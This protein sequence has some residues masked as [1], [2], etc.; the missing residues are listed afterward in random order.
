MTPGQW[1]AKFD[2]PKFGDHKVLQL[3][4]QVQFDRRPGLEFRP[5]APCRKPEQMPADAWKEQLQGF[6]SNVEVKWH[7]DVDVQWLQLV[8]LVEQASAR[9][10]ATFS[11]S[12]RDT[13]QR[14]RRKG[15]LPV[16]QPVLSHGREAGRRCAES[17]LVQRLCKFQGR[18][19]EAL[20]HEE[21]DAALSACIRRHWPREV[22][23]APFEQALAFTQELL[24][25]TRASRN[26]SE[27]ASVAAA[28]GTGWQ[29][30]DPVA[31][32]PCLCLAGGGGR[33]LRGPDRDEPDHAGSTADPPGL[34][35]THMEQATAT[36][37]D[38]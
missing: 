35:E 27:T 8:E 16:V 13:K 7:D 9:A 31:Q 4:W 17:G 14:Y 11:G 22:P 5:T 24:Q 21:V 38:R 36:D 25:R 18:L 1:Q 15:S 23:R 12:S 37:G 2:T 33:H 10:I 30:G 29:G 32:Q 20:R 3:R 26:L 28:N 19:L 6:F 34:L